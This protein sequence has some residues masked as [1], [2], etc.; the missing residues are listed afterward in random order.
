MS[1]LEKLSFFSG[2]ILLMLHISCSS[3]TSSVP[4]D[5]RVKISIKSVG[6]SA[7][8][9]LSK[10][11]SSVTITNAQVVI[12]EIEF[13]S[14]TA[15]TLDFEFETPF[16][17]DLALDTSLHV[18]TTVQVPFGTYEEMEI[19]IA[20]LDEEDGAAFTQN[21]ELQNLSIRAEGFLDGDP[22]KTFVFTSD[23]SVTQER[24][25]EPPLVIDET[26][27]ST[28]VV[29]T[30]DLGT[31]FVDENNN[32]LDPTLENNRRTIENNI[33]ASIKVFED[34]DDD[35]EADEDDDDGEGGEDDD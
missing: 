7:S 27:P 3:P 28:N 9:S 11:A 10:L 20:K 30:I 1:L 26:T 5:G 19:E 17:Q 13:E 23:I 35:G 15:D 2:V 25:F 12:E 32:P 22:A 16:V 18:I 21:P 31:W 8:N 4:T 29:L 6:S 34:E 14:D 24:E 33:K